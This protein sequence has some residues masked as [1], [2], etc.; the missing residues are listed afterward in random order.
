MSPEEQ[1][2]APA[3]NLQWLQDELHNAKVQAGK[4]EQQVEQLQTLL[5]DLVDRSRHQDEAIAAINVQLATLVQ[6]QEDVRQLQTLT[7]RLREEQERARG[8]LE[9]ATRQQQAESER[10]RSERAELVRQVEDLERRV[11]SWQER[12]G[13]IEE[14]G[15]RY[16]ESAAATAQQATDLQ[17]RL[18]DLEGRSSRNTEAANRLD[19][20]LPELERSVENAVR[21]EETGNERTRL[22][23]DV[24]RRM[25]SEA[26]DVTRQLQELSEL[27]ERLELGRVERQRLEAR[28][29]E[30]EEAVNGL[31]GNRDE[32]QR[33]LAALE[34]KHH[35]YEGR[36]DA[37]NERLDEYRQQLAE[38]LL[39]LTQSQEQLK[40]R[41]IGDLEREI[42]ELEQHAL[43]LFHE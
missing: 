32:H 13:S 6:V 36:L 20:R 19:Q 16:Q 18:E 1:E 12:Q 22:L 17:Q 21:A 23:T 5:S 3:G 4:L 43:G 11:A 38:H 41:Q 34:G 25:E 40:R 28:F 42:K 26:A 29:A 30:L 37:L 31:S 7:G 10:V 35:G 27:P 24:V 9:E 14:T 39:K 15:R 8:H 33:L 2:E